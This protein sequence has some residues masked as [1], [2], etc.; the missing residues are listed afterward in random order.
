MAGKAVMDRRIFPLP[1]DPHF[2]AL[3]LGEVI[4]D[5]A[6]LEVLGRKGAVLRAFVQLCNRRR[7]LVTSSAEATGTS[8]PASPRALQVAVDDIC[9][10]FEDPASPHSLLPGGEDKAVT[11]GSLEEYC[12]LMSFIDSL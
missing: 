1:L 10:T 6:A 7:A 9:L 4:T 5:D 12:N 8:D 2:F 11:D 3:A